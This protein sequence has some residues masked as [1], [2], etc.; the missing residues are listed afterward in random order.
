MDFQSFAR[1]VRRQLTA[2]GRN[3]LVRTSDRLEAFAVLAV[4]VIGLLAIPLAARVEDENYRARLPTAIEEM[5]TRHSV[6]A[7]A[8]EGSNGLP[9]DFYNPNYVRVQWHEG[10]RVRTEEVVSPGTIKA[11]DPLV[12][13]LDQTGKVVTTPL[14]PGDVEFSA[15]TVGWTVWVMAVVF[16]GLA[17]VAVRVWL[18]RSR[19]RAWEREL[20]LMAHNDDGW[21]NRRA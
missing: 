12:I 17:A 9:T 19:S 4:L 7:V 13:W 5:Q 3:P 14:T 16:S 1:S 8:V 10:T 15:A 20:T 21:A 2:L 18:D 6:Q 11:G